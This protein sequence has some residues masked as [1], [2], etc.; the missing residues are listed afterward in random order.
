MPRFI[1]GLCAASSAL[2]YCRFESLCKTTV[3]A[4]FLKTDTGKKIGIQFQGEVRRRRKMRVAEG[5]VSLQN[6]LPAFYWPVDGNGER[7]LYRAPCRLF[8]VERGDRQRKVAE[9]GKR[10]VSCSSKANVPQQLCKD[11][12]DVAKEILVRFPCFFL[13][14]Q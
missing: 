3:K 8:G 4:I 9:N 2:G 14:L 12:A 6:T 1:E 11:A 5:A 10:K 13:C 7:D